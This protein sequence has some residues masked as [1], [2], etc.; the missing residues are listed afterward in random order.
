MEAVDDGWVVV[1]FK[2]EQS[3]E[4]VPVQWTKNKVSCFWPPNET[5]SRQDIVYLIKQKKKPDMRN[6]EEHDVDIIGH[7]GKLEN[8]DLYL[9]K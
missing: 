2:N 1:F 9:C 5:Y 7:Y 3:V 6:W 8:N 4:A